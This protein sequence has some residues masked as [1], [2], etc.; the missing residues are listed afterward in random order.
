[1]KNFDL[2][3]IREHDANGQL[4][5]SG[6]LWQEQSL[7]ISSAF[8]IV[9]A[10]T[11]GPFVLA[12]ALMSSG[13]FLAG[14]LTLFIG[15]IVVGLTLW[16]AIPRPSCGLIFERDGTMRTPHGFPGYR[17][18]EIVTG[19]HD[20]V[21]SLEAKPS[22]G[23]GNVQMFQVRML[24]KSGDLVILSEH[25]HEAAA[26]KVAAQLSRALEDLRRSVATAGQTAETLVIGIG[27]QRR[28]YLIS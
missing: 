15:P 27:E 13:S 22:G 16:A 18:R 28:E 4:I 19:H 10:S 5:Q 1:M 12:V 24:F 17:R 7:G 25:L 6:C 14:F 3:R 21:V 26:L 20:D 2:K 23:P 8:L 11:I 9:A